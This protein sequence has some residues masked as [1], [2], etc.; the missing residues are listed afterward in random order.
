MIPRPMKD[1]DIARGAILVL[2]NWGWAAADRFAEQAYEYL[3]GGEYAPKFFV[4]GSEDRSIPIA[5][6][7]AYQRSMRMNGA[8]DLIWLAVDTKHAGEGLGTALTDIRLE[9]IRRRGGTFASL[10]TQKPKYFNRFGFIT[11][12]HLGNNWVEMIAQFKL[13]EI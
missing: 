4:V 9:E 1:S 10:V 13:A 11:A 7:S 5:G 8:F 3:K 2:E 12:Y 6:F